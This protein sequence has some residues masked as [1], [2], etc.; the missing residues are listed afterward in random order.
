MKLSVFKNNRLIQELEL[1]GAPIDQQV[2][3]GNHLQN[4][5]GPSKSLANEVQYY[6]GRSSDCK[7]HLDDKKI[8]R[9]HAILKNKAGLWT[10]LK[11]SEFGHIRVNGE[12]VQE[13]RLN[14]GDLIGVSDFVISVLNN[15]VN[16]FSQT[17]ANESNE[18]TV[19][20]T[21]NAESST[22]VFSNPDEN[23]DNAGSEQKNNAATESSLESS[24]ESSELSSESSNEIPEELRVDQVELDKVESLALESNSDQED[25]QSDLNE[26]QIELEE[27]PVK[28]Q[29]NPSIQGNEDR[30][31][32]FNLSE[33]SKI[34]LGGD[35]SELPSESSEENESDQQESTQTE[36]ASKE[37]AN[38]FTLEGS[39][40]FSQQNGVS[41]VDE[42]SKTQVLNSFIQLSLEIFGEKAPYD[43]FQMDSDTVVIGRDPK[44]C[45]I[46]IDD[47]EVS[48]EHCKLLK[49][50]NSYTLIDLN[51]SNGTIL[52]GTRINRADLG[53]GDEFLVGSTS[54]KV[55]IKSDLLD[56]EKDRL[57]PVAE[58][59]V[60]EVEEVI[61]VAEHFRDIN[62]SQLKLGTKVGPDLTGISG[63][64]VD[65]DKS[66]KAK[67]NK[68]NSR[69]KLIYGSV[70]LVLLWVL[71][72][73]EQ[74]PPPVQKKDAAK[75]TKVNT[76]QV[77]KVEEKKYSPQELEILES[78]Y[79]VATSLIQEQKYRDALK[80]LDKIFLITNN[81]KRARDYENV[82][83][84]SLAEL[85][86]EE[87]KLKDKEEKERIKLEVDGLVLKAE[88]SVK[89]R[90]VTTAEA[91]FNRILQ[92]DPE[93]NK[94]TELKF[95]L[96]EWQKAEQQKSLAETQK[97]AERQRRINELKPGK[98]LYL[99]KEWYKAI[100]KL[101]EF[102][103]I[104]EMDDDL[105]K[106]GSDMLADS[107]KNLEELVSPLLG[108]ARSLN[109]GQD[110]KGSYETY[111]ELLR[112]DPTNEEA[113]TQMSL[114]KDQLFNRA[115]KIY[116][117]AMVSESMSLFEDA[118]S[119][120]QEVQ[121]ISPS[122]SEYFRK[123]SL[124]LKEY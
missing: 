36:S 7:I 95:E 40:D 112:I 20:P 32:E 120:F 65:Q 26:K 45:G 113:L 39:D 60:V 124:K 85:E 116:R 59:Q 101:E 46:V 92:L 78:S 114:I 99:K 104:E 117:E 63:F 44:K 11:V 105:I 25:F 86:E 37:Q 58:N 90:E 98:D 106:E 103:R 62:T 82:A 77:K 119:K 109:E 94:V 29:T 28:E 22:V 71:L 42:D 49:N 69:Q 84:K 55:I 64:K 100:I 53:N 79:L 110:L 9:H 2:L 83:K 54:F 70:F 33:K 18:T 111:Q 80:E 48:L 67:W 122:D 61:E 24:E 1:D 66:L 57:M 102:L 87:R 27:L 21:Q 10:I 121:Q 91:F 93:N 19:M 72:D 118:K 30:E 97:K 8:S 35:N 115:K 4:M 23:A 15:N 68:L 108:K 123:A 16:K 3:M 47:S 43:R 50:N 13:S 56:S 107:R 17:A 76:D 52:N 81:Y 89:K 75:S 51:S 6:L 88:E 96:D 34:E 5:Q 31:F 73:T 38:N 14:N 12:L 74:A 41:L